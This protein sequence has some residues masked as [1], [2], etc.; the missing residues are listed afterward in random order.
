MS[1]LEAMAYGKAVIGSDIGG[2]PELI[3]HGETGYLF[4]PGDHN[5]LRSRLL[6]LMENP[7]LRHRFGAAGRKR[8]EEHFS[9]DRHNAALMQ[10]YSKV[11]EGSKCEWKVLH[12]LERKSRSSRS[13]IYRHLNLSLQLALSDVLHLAEPDASQRRSHARTLEKLPSG[14]DNLNV[15]GGEPTLRRDL[16][17]LIDVVYPK[18]RIT[19]ISSNG[20]A[21]TLL[22]I[23]KKYPT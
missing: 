12:P 22:P 14:F 11:I 7:A 16:A 2:I 1:V 17:D 13:W 10:L 5:S 8:A 6:E 15:S 4:P 23:I 21:G 3:V 19:E 9:L 20:E 18:A